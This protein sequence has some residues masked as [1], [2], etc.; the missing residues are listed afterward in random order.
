MAR[1]GTNHRGGRP[2]RSVE[3]QR[4]EAMLEAGIA[5]TGHE[6]PYMTLWQAIW[7]QAL[8]GDI[9]A[10]KLIIEQTYG[11]P[12]QVLA[13]EKEPVELVIVKAID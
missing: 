3:Q 10:I 1:T 2:P 6:R 13:T 12:R 4:L 11:K 5:V 9:H 7:R 8:D